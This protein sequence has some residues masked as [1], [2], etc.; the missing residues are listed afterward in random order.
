[1]GTQSYRTLLEWIWKLDI[2]ITNVMLTN[3]DQIPMWFMAAD[4][5]SRLHRHTY[6]ALGNEAAKVLDKHKLSYFKLPHP[7]PRNRKLNNEDF[8]DSELAECYDYL[9]GKW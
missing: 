1:V 7:S 2:D 9:K 5:E 8:I 3:K 4:D 6:I